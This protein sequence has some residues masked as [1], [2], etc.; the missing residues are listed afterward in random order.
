[1]KKTFKTILTKSYIVEIAAENKEEASRFTEL[2]T[3][4]SQDISTKE[5]RKKHNF[6]IENMEC[7]VNEV[8]EVEKE[9][10]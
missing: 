2:F 8:V 3:G 6:K 4:D 10:P 5:D 9:N 7:T 1:M